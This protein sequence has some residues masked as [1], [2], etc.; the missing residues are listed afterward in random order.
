MN[1]KEYDF[2][3]LDVIGASF[4]ENPVIEIVYGKT[5]MPVELEVKPSEAFVSTQVNPMN[6]NSL[7][8]VVLKALKSN[9]D[10]KAKMNGRK[11]ESI[12]DVFENEFEVLSMLDEDSTTEVL[13]MQNKEQQK[14]LEE[15]RITNRRIVMNCAVMPRFIETEEFEKNKTENV[16]NKIFPV[17]LID[18]FW[19]QQMADI[20][21][22]KQLGIWGEKAEAIGKSVGADDNTGFDSNGD[23]VGV[24]SES[25]ESSTI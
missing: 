10:F 11:V 21:I 20:A 3:V 19:L 25:M 22:G 24:D 7:I 16:N 5:K 6:N 2:S 17:E 13:S 12:A 18:D 1:K 4:I 9:P 14:V 8:K 23:S 15:N